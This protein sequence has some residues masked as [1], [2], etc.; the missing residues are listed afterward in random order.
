MNSPSLGSILGRPFSAI[1]C[2]LR[3]PVLLLLTLTLIS[4]AP[5]WAAS[6]QWSTVGSTGTVDEADLAI[7]SFSNGFASISAAAAVPAT[8]DIRYS[9]VAVDGLFDF[10]NGY[11]LTVR[12]RDNGVSARVVVR[13]KEYSRNTGATNTLLTFDSNGFAQD[14]NFQLQTVSFCAPPLDFFNNAYFIE[15][16][17]DKTAA[18]GD[19]QLGLVQLGRTNC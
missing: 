2:R 17:L 13:L 3:L 12:Y 4:D 8:L 5:A 10:A 15:A 14:G 11:A 9:V 1:R 18:A 16:Q 6:K 19:P 7:A